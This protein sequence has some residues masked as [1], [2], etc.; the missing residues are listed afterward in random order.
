MMY[1]QKDWKGE[2]SLIWTLFQASVGSSVVLAGDRRDYKVR[3][4]EEGIN[5][6]GWRAW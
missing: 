3:V 4:G 6:G 1:M 2:R 5:V